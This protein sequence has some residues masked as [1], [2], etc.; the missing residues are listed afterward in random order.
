MPNTTY[1]RS[2]GRNH[3][4]R[5]RYS[6]YVTKGYLKAIVGVPESKWLN[7]TQG[8]LGPLAVANN[9]NFTYNLNNVPQGTT[10]NQRIGDVISNKSL[11]I[12]L[13]IARAAVDSLVRVIVFWYK[14]GSNPLA[15]NPIP[16]PSVIAGNL[17]E[18]ASYQS[19][20]NKDQG[21]S[22]WI[23]FDKTYSIAA[24]QTQLVVDEIWRKL[25]CQTE[26]VS[27]TV[28]AQTSNGLYITAISNQADAA[29]QPLMT[30]TARLTYL[31]L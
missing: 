8:T 19:P 18:T 5:R 1:A 10:Q 14:D 29:N 6:R 23:K 25:K 11:H 30:F 17:L 27:D 28:S 26:F 22:Y 20:V 3:F 21:G 2:Q 4:G 15:S 31:D 16:L 7:T 9:F 24:G 12:R 13:D